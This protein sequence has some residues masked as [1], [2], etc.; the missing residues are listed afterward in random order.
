MHFMHCLKSSWSMRLKLIFAILVSINVCT[1]LIF[2]QQLLISR[3]GRLLKLSQFFFEGC[4]SS[5]LWREVA[6][7]FHL[8]TRRCVHICGH[9]ELGWNS[10]AVSLR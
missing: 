6:Q 5:L 8:W 7:V 4:A 10:E 9:V 3:F 1:F 2:Q